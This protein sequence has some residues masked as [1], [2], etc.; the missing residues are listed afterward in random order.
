M[1][2]FLIVATVSSVTLLGLL[3][4]FLLGTVRAALS[5]HEREE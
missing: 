5:S 2:G 4:Y 1:S 3:I